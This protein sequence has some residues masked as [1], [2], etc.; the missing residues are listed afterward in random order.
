VKQ[1]EPMDPS[2]RLSAQSRSS[3]ERRTPTGFVAHV[4]SLH[5][6]PAR[7]DRN[8]EPLEDARECLSIVSRD[9]LL[10][11]HLHERVRQT[12]LDERLPGDPESARFLVNLAQEVD[13]EVDVHALDVPAGAD[14]FAEVHVR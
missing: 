1:T 2:P 11:A 3:R 6:P 8:I 7:R 9:K 14:R 10:L 12:D 4:S 13:G 5:Q